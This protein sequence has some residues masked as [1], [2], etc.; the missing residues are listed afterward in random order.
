MCLDELHGPGYRW[1]MELSCIPTKPHVALMP[2]SSAATALEVELQRFSMNDELKADTTWGW[3]WGGD[4][5]SV[6]KAN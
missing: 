3:G 6:S 1:S 2:F 4:M 5:L